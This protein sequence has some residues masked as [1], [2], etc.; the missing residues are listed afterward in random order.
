MR[1]V[2]LISSI[3]VRGLKEGTKSIMYHPTISLKQSQYIWNAP[4]PSELVWLEQS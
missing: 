2:Y 3:K 4:R 1:S